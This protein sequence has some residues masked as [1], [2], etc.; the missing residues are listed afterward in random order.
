MLAASQLYA[1][2]CNAFCVDC[3]RVATHLSREEAEEEEQLRQGRHSDTGS[4]S[5]YYANAIHR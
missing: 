2:N 5:G 1:G 4:G 3:T